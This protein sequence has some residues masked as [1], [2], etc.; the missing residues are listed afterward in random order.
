MEEKAYSGKQEEVFDLNEIVEEGAQNAPGAGSPAPEA[1][2]AASPAEDEL[3]E[4]TDPVQV[5]DDAEAGLAESE[6]PEIAVL[7]DE[8]VVELQPGEIED[9]PLTMPGMEPPAP[10]VAGALFPSSSEAQEAEPAGLPCPVTG[11]DARPDDEAFLSLAAELESRVNELAAKRAEEARLF[12]ERVAEVEERFAGALAALE[13]R[14]RAL[15]AENSALRE[16]LAVMGRRLD[17]ASASAEAQAE[18]FRAELAASEARL[19]DAERHAE[20]LV[21]KLAALEE[22]QAEAPASCLADA[23]FMAGLADAVSR[24]VDERLEQVQFVAAGEAEAQGGMPPVPDDA[25]PQEEPLRDAEASG[26]VAEEARPDPEGAALA[27]GATEEGCALVE[28]GFPTETPLD[29]ASEPEKASSEVSAEENEL[30]EAENIEIFEENAASQVDEGLSSIINE[31]AEHV[32]ELEERM[33]E[34]E[35]RCEQEAALAAAR[36]IREEIAALKAEAALSGQ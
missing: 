15:S 31:I 27:D 29:A 25:E 11:S 30:S 16:E 7:D 23:A 5:Y 33:A 21:L 26:S 2:P 14:E 34:W 12:G 10:E 18:A 1:V 28:E 19:A 35:L 8:A 32:G 17:E 24:A 22:R 9:A 4:L 3:I 6:L 20:G 13:E 36:V